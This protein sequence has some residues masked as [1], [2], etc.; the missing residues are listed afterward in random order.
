MSGPAPIAPIPEDRHGRILA[1]L[2]G[3]SL[4]LSRD[5]QA[6]ALAAE[7][8][9]DATKLA[10]AFHR[11][12]RA[13]RQCLALEARLIHDRAREA[14]A[15]A[16]TRLKLDDHRRRWTPTTDRTGRA[17]PEREW[18]RL[19][20]DLDAFET[21]DDDLDELLVPPELRRPSDGPPPRPPAP[22][23][24]APPRMPSG[25]PSAAWPRGQGPT[26]ADRPGAPP[27]PPNSS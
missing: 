25:G 9:E 16:E 1:E 17:Q 10:A 6:R 21:F 11:T 4:E 5:L 27:P 19:H 15:R 8:V 20:D 26:P 13:V 18:E 24:P 23:P 2:A 3:L 7:T 12:A 14:R 22:R